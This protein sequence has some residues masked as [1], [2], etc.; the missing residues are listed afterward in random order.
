MEILQPYNNNTLQLIS[1][2]NNYQFQL[3]DLDGG[4]V[5]LS[6]F[7]EFGSFQDFKDLEQEKDFYVKDDELFLKPNE[8]LDAAGFSEGNYNLQFDFLKRL[9]TSAFNISQIS[10]S[11]KEI[12]LSIPTISIDNVQQANITEFMNEGVD[13]YQFNSNLE[14]SQGRLIPINGYA[15]DEVTGNKRTLVI[16]LN[17]PLPSDVVTLST[18]FNISNKFLSSQTETIFFIDREGLA[19]SGLGLE[20]DTSFITEPTSINDVF[21]NYNNITG[22]SGLNVINKINNQQKDLNL[23]IDYKTFD[24]HVFFGSAKSKLENFKI[25]RFIFTDK[26]L[27]INGK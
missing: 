11:R 24:G 1:D 6:V 4:A 9:E 3:S 26:F 17:E 5:K 19:V 15:F 14:L 25:R 16:K 12:R 7:S 21:S 2:D 20:I 18:D 27:L 13:S 8:Y 23:N 22:S 10:P